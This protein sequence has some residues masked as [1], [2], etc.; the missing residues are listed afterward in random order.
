[1]NWRFLFFSDYLL[2]LP[3]LFLIR[4]EGVWSLSCVAVHFFSP[5]RD[6]SRKSLL[7][8]LDRSCLYVCLSYEGTVFLPCGDADSLF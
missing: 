2:L 3:L 7:I 4:I 1:M 8:L 6:F 5:G